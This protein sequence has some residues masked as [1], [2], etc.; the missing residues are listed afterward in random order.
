MKMTY[1]DNEHDRVSPANAGR[2]VG[3]LHRR[4]H[5]MATRRRSRTTA[6]AGG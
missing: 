2:L 6:G 5:D 1:L 4:L 3:A